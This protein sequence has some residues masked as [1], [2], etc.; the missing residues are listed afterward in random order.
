MTSNNRLPMV[1]R[2][3]D[4]LPAIIIGSL[5]LVAGFALNDATI[6]IIDQHWSEDDPKKRNGW[7]KMLYAIILIVIVIVAIISILEIDHKN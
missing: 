3:K 7:Y 4:E 2:F 1:E 6:S 5:A